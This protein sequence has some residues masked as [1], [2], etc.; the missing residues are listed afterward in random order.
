MNLEDIRRNYENFDDEKLIEIATKDIQSLRK[1][2]IPIL[3]AELFKRNISLADAQERTSVKSNTEPNT[4][5]KKEDKIFTKENIEFMNSFEIP[6]ILKNGKA[7]YVKGDITTIFS[8][9]LAV[10]LV[11]FLFKSQFGSGVKLIL[12][13]IIASILIKLIL[14]KMNFGKIAEVHPT[15]IILPKYPTVNFGMFRIMILIRIASN[16]LGMLEFNYRDISRVYQKDTFTN[17]GYYLDIINSTS[18]ETESH[19]VFLEVL[20]ENDR[21]QILEIIKQKSDSAA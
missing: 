20:S 7:Y 14:K 15:K 21:N 12:W 8:I 9:L 3:E 6:H 4:K 17:K 11:L 13:T 1:E 19:R 5:K 18:R 10:L 2:V 16:Q